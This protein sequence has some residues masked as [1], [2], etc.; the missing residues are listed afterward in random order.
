MKGVLPRLVDWARCA[1]KKDFYPAMATLVSLVQKFFSSPYTCSS[2][3]II[4]NLSKLAFIK[5]IFHM[6]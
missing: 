6:L 2:I 5:I 4:H 3:G 1:R